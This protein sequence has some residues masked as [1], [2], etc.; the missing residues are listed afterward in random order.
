M[1]LS[2]PPLSIPVHLSKITKCRYKTSL[3][4]LKALTPV[5]SL[6]CIRPLGP[7]RVIGSVELSQVSSAGARP[8]YTSLTVRTRDS[9]GLTIPLSIQE[10]SLYKISAATPFESWT[11]PKKTGAAFS[12][13]GVSRYHRSSS[14][15]VFLFCLSVLRPIQLI[16]ESC[17]VRL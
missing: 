11:L 6:V 16:L 17:F 7:M 10:Y 12:P 1:K 4:R 2:T 5:V 3:R 15:R 14:R 9:C 8:S 13:A